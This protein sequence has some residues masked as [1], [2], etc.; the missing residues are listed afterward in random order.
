M[1]TVLPVQTACWVEEV[2]DQVEVFGLVERLEVD[3]FQVTA[4]GEVVGRVEDERPAAAHAGGE[5][6]ARWC[7]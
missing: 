2:A 3:H 6:S 1:A 5:V 7:R 4:A